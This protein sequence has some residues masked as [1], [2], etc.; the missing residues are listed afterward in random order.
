MG[1]EDQIF[2]LA[3]A[4]TMPPGP[5]VILM[6]IDGQPRWLVREGA[7]LPAVVEELNRIGTHV[8]RHGLWVAQDCGV[9]KPP[10]PL[11]HVS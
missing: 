6:E 4:D 11:R 10:P 8:V 1:I 5:D 3:P 2:Q 7:D 9:Q